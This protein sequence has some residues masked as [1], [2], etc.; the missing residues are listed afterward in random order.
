MDSMTTI[1]EAEIDRLVP[2]FY[3][4]VRRD[5]VLGPIFD[6][7]VADWPP[8]LDKLR[9]FWSSVLLSSGRYKGQPMAAHIH[10]EAAMTPAHFDRWLALWREVSDALLTPA[11]AALCQDKAARIAESLLL[12]VEF[13]RARDRPGRMAS[14]ANPR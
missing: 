9:A 6:G 12:G 3:D 14:P 2:A 8:H 10:H 4:R 11:A 5:P 7:A 13:H 1:T